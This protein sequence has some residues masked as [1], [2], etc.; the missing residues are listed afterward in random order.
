VKVWILGSGSS[1]NSAVVE[2][3]GAYLMVDAGF[4]LPELV[5]RLRAADIPPAFVDHVVLTHG[6]RDHVVGAASGAS[7]YGWQVWGSLGTVWRWR[8][9]REI[10]LLPF[11]PGQ[12]FD[13]GPFRVT[14]IPTSHDVDDSAA[15]V[16]SVPATGVSAAFCTDLGHA[17]Q[18]IVDGLRD[19]NLVL[20]ESNYDPTMLANGPYPPE[21]RDRVGSDIGHLSNAQAG[22]VARAI[23][24][25]DLEYLLL[26]HVSRKNNQGELAMREMRAALEGTAFAGELLVAPQHDVLGPL[27][28]TP[29]SIGR[30]TAARV[31]SPAPISRSLPPTQP[32]P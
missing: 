4:D 13:A 28:L 3:D 25:P 26:G 15:I 8:A 22:Q 11:E 19:V 10:P 23:A 2:H 7:I 24:H 14:T 5:T 12:G 18:G 20:L 16:V 6:H 17:P 27:T 29:H 1:G 21:V 9:L 32:S 30:A 31:D